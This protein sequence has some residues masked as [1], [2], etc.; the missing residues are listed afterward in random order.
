MP[1]KSTK[2]DFEKALK[3]LEQLVEKMEGGELTLEDSMHH[4]ERGIALTRACQKALV[5]AEQKVQILLQKE[6]KADMAPFT[7][8][9]NND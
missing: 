7:P 6:G 3:E 2:F 1:K 4:F 5:E 9:D 8:E